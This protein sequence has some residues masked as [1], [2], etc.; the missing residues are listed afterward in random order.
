MAA[1]NAIIAADPELAAAYQL[2][3]VTSLGGTIRSEI[4]GQGG[5]AHGLGKT[6]KVRDSAHGRWSFNYAVN[7]L[8]LLL[9]HCMVW[10]AH[11]VQG[12]ANLQF[13]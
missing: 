12:M 4:V 11:G 5:Q 13:D 8:L 2:L 1:I 7:G 3:G 10:C 9:V 6:P